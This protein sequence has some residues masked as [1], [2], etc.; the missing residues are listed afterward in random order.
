MRFLPALVLASL[1]ACSSSV[2]LP[3]VSPANVQLFMPWVEP[4]ESYKDLDQFIIDWPGARRESEAITKLHAQAAEVGADA[5]LVDM[6]AY[7]DATP[8]AVRRHKGLYKEEEWGSCGDPERTLVHARAIYF[9]SLHP[10]L[11]EKK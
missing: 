11:A 7:G 3:P 10:E 8:C 2:E 1:V 4:E 5:L 9:P 6:I